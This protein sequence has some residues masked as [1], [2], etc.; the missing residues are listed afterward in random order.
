MCVC[1]RVCVCIYIYTHTP[2]FVCPVTHQ[3]EDVLFPYHGYCKPC[4]IEQGV[5][6]ISF[7]VNALFFSEKCPEVEFLD[8]VVALILIS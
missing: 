2:H 6:Y 8:N 4:C 5:T 3:W 1:M 7:Q